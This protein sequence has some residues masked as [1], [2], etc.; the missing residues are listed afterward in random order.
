MVKR[1]RRR[2]KRYRWGTREAKRKV[3]MEGKGRE[4]GIKRGTWN[5]RGSECGN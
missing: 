5:M 1:L 2:K 4:K 3:R